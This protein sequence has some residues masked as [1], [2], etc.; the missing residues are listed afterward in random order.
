[1]TKGCTL[2]FAMLC[3]FTANAQTVYNLAMVPESLKTKANV[4]THLE[5]INLEVSGLDEM[6]LSVHKVFTV[7]NEEGKNALTFKKYT[8]KYVS[9]DDAEIKVFDQSGKQVN[10]YKKKR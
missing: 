3:F 5:N 2:A 4:V 6:K 1:M 8:S 9:L 10:K 7:V